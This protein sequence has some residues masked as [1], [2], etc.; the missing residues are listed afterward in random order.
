MFQ[1]IY[2]KENLP[3][4]LGHEALK[5]HFAAVQKNPYSILDTN[6]KPVLEYALLLR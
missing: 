2:H 6:Q 3:V 1:D 4:R 5:R